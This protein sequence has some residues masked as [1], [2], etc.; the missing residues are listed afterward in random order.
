MTS[1]A[2]CPLRPSNPG[3]ILASA[4]PIRVRL[5][6]ACACLVAVALLCG[7]A[8][9]SSVGSAES[10]A[11][12]ETASSA[13]AGAAAS[14]TDSASPG[15]AADASASAT[16]AA[17]VATTE[18]LQPPS[19]DGY[20]PLVSFTYH[21]VDPKQKNSLTLT[22]ATFEA[23]LKLLQAAGYQTVTSRDLLKHQT[24]GTPLPSKPVMLTF[25]D[26][27]RN[28]YQY[29]APLL[30][31]Y[32]FKGV[33]FVNPQTIGTY[34][35][36]M[37]RDMVISLDKRGH[38]IESHTWQHVRLTRKGNESAE[39]FQKRMK[40]QFTL[41]NDWIKKVVGKRPVAICYPFGFYDTETVGFARDGGYQLGFTVDEGVADARTWDAMV[42]KRF[43][44]DRSYSLDMFKSLLGAAPLQARDIQPGP[45][46]RVVGLETTITI[47]I[48]D[49]PASVKGIKIWGGPSVKATTIFEKDGR[50]YASAP[51]R[52]SAVGLKAITVKAKDTSGRKYYASW[53]LTMGDPKQ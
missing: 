17:S 23:Q 53:T 19:Y 35:A 5:A 36:Y 41:S 46:S 7:C 39:S 15:G 3:R 9:A 27:W 26:G 51:L 30:D 42:M 12:R 48:T 29:A 49:V 18:S 10:G 25:D 47:D 40:R 8:K 34:G 21:H 2:A 24:D 50:R 1:A 14:T 32:G 28:Q 4:C 44:M 11:A 52:R 13:T 22:P 45:G 20:E 16:S 38:D 6:V 31:K 37:N 33:F 43:T